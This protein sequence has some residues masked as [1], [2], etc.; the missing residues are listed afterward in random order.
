MK[1][2]EKVSGSHWDSLNSHVN[3]IDVLLGSG[4]RPARWAD[5]RRHLSFAE[6]GDLRDI[7]R[8]DWP[9]VRQGLQQYSFEDEPLP[10]AVDDLSKLVSSSS[11]GA[12]VS[13]LKWD[14]LDDAGFE[15]LLFNLISAAPGYEN[16]EWLYSDCRHG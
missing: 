13:Q 2:Y 1:S 4:R 11:T 15:R 3:Q 10:I 12:V 6:P 14:A 5:L 16:P 7:Q 9:K 8:L